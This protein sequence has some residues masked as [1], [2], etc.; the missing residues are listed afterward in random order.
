MGIRKQ[1][2]VWAGILA[3][4]LLGSAGVA[5]ATGETTILTVGFQSITGKEIPEARQA[6][7]SDAL[8]Q[9]VALAFA[10]VVPPRI[11]AANLEFL[12]SRI[13]PAAEDYISTFRVL[14]EATHESNYL[15]G[16][17]S[18]VQSEML[19]QTL[20]QAGILNADGDRPRIL[21]LIAEQTVSD[22]LPRYWWGNN[23]EPYHSHAE[24]QIADKMTQN[25]F[26]VVGS[27]EERPDPR[28]HGIQFKSI[29]DTGAAVDLAEEL[30][31]DLVM[32]GRAG[33]TESIN[34]MEN[35]TVFDAVVHLNVLDVTTGK[36]IAS[37]EYQA[38]AK[39][40]VD[41]SGDVRA[42]VRAVDLAYADLSAQLDQFLAQKSEKETAFTVRIK[43]NQFL[44]RFIALKKRFTEI[45]EI[46]NVTPREIGSDQAVLEMVYKGS[47][48]QFAHRIMRT[49][50]DGFGIEIMELTDTLVRIRFIDDTNTWEAG[51]K[52]HQ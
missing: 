10:R 3:I 22:L 31:A 37:G 29:Y 26:T 40:E 45:K 27:G 23:P 50:F 42:I 17:E 24:T 11:F 49:I 47:P 25:R 51:E 44:P 33:A 12:H 43:G 35:E 34:R 6:A 16:V 30:N 13:L 21:L 18:R 46:Q 5:S 9:A 36:P 7:V 52:T 8:K 19:I 2:I 15:V 32:L 4:L 20:A 41:Q 38:A 48:E 1:A 28:D 39:S 14:G